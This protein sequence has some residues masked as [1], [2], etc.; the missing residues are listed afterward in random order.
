MLCADCIHRN[1]NLQSLCTVK[2]A[3]YLAFLLALNFSGFGQSTPAWFPKAPPLPEPTG[4]VVRASTAQQILELGEGLSTNATLVIEPG[5]Y[6]LDR[7][8]VLR[9]KQNVTIRSASGDPTSV[10]LQ[11]KGWDAGNERDDIIHIGNCTNVLIA[12]ITF[13]EAR[14]YGVKVQ[15]EDG[16]RDIHIYNCR[17]RNIGVRAIKGSAGNDPEVRAVNGS[18][19]F[20]DF[21]NTKVPPADWLFGGDYIS[22]I[23]MMALDKWTFS[24]NSFRNIKG[25]NGGGRAAI[26]IWVRSRNVLLQRN[27]I[28]NCDRGIAFGNP[29]QSTANKPGE[30]LTYVADSVIQNNMITGGADCGIELWHVDGIKVLHN[31]IW[32]PEQNFGRGIRVGTGT[33]NTIVENNLIHGGIQ[34]EGG[35][36]Q[37]ITNL[38]KR[39]DEQFVNTTA[40]DLALAKATEQCAPVVPYDIRGTQRPATCDFGAWEYDPLPTNHWVA[41]MRKVHARF[42]GNAGTLL[43]IGDSITFSGAYWSPLASKPK[44]MAAEVEAKYDPVKKYLKPE[45]FMQKGPEFGNKGSM[46]IKW[47]RENIS[48]WLKNLNPEAAVIMFGSNDATQLSGGDYAATTREVVEAC[49]ANGTIPILT[50]PPPRAGH[51]GKMLMFANAI[52]E[53]GDELHVPV[54]DYSNEIFERRPFDWDGSAAEFKNVRG[55]TYEVPTL[56][57][58][59]GVHPSNSRDGVNDFSEIDLSSNGYTLRNYLTLVAYSDVVREVLQRQ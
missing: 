1:K 33:T 6:K 43:Q 29:G 37:V 31:S 39:L 46:T 7:P 40:G 17:F 41:P 22:A 11:G 14:S 13:A 8:L 24:D 55:D 5:V 58:R 47:A 27:W 59:D 10:T 48:T 53:I 36:A 51:V 38:A 2:T 25:R 3:L 23:D 9:A 42:K 57:S 49:L 52:R 15:A 12:G 30:R 35:S 54:I 20:C 32:R 21:E 34:L 18:V 4:N 50:T 56:I 44:N 45:L 28:F 16:P 19:R 26:F